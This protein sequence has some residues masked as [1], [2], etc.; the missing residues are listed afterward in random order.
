V[1]EGQLGRGMRAAVLTQTV[2][3]HQEVDDLYWEMV[4]ANKTH[5]IAIVWLGNVHGQFLLQ[6]AHPF[7]VVYG[8]AK[9][10]EHVVVPVEMVRALFAPSMRDLDLLLKRL[11]YP[12]RVFITGT[13]PP[14][15]ERVIRR[16]LT[17]E[18]YFIKI[19]AERRL[20]IASVPLSPLA[21]R[22]AT[23]AIYQD[24]LAE[25]AGRAG[26]H[27]VPVPNQAIDD[28]GCLREELCTPDATHGNSLYGAEMWKEIFAAI[29]RDKNG[30]GSV[31]DVPRK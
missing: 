4:V 11:D 8:A 17:R 7:Q 18:P 3:V 22:K 31:P 25:S 15:P 19:A 28:D 14:K 27:F 9:P 2:P 24:L 6:P 13:P 30:K 21:L 23:W 12:A 1:G 5:P 20:D 16:G 10:C 26:A 29:E